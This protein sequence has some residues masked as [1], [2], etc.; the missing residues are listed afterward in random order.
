MS[1]L[2][3]DT[4][5][6]VTYLAHTAPSIID[7]ALAEGRV[8]LPPLVAAELLSGKMTARQR[9]ELESFLLELPLCDQHVEHWMRVGHLRSHLFSKGVSVSTP[10]AHIAQCALDLKAEL[11]SE[12]QIFSKIAQKTSLRLV[13]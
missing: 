6:W 3:V 13:T 7:E 2:V 9:R 11:L 8:Y 4:S 5:S 12:D 1:A 10:D